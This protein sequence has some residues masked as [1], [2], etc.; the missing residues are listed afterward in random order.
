MSS[1][2]DLTDSTLRSPAGGGCAGPFVNRTREAPG[3]TVEPALPARA[4]LRP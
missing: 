2:T 1:E 4:E 3:R